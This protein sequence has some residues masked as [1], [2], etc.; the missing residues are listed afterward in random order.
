MWF[1]HILYRIIDKVYFQVNLMP[2]EDAFKEA[3]TILT[4]EY[5]TLISKF[6]CED[7]LKSGID[8]FRFNFNSEMWG[9]REAVRKEIVHKIEM[10]LEDLFGDFHENYLGN[11][12]HLPTGTRWEI[13][14]SG[15]IPGIDIANKELSYY[16]QIKSKFN[17]MNSS[18]AKRLAGQLDRVKKEKPD[19]IVGCG[20]VIAGSSR[21]AIGENDIKKVAKVFKGKE[22]FAFITGNVTEMDDLILQFPKLLK[23]TRDK[24]DFE[25]LLSDATDIIINELDK[26]A[27][28]MNIDL[29]TYL[30][31][32]A[33]K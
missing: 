27:K 3:I 26:K 30:Y 5:T 21:S 32:H 20:W 1:L 11:C 24:Y 18:S 12:V 19:S 13:I 9:T 28:L 17:S 14:P 31:K 7:F 25:K 2:Q 15:K 4:N 33:V 29:K 23:E 10:K 6:S 8:P 22:L 16:L